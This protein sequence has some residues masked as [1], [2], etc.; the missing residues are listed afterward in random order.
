MAD[1]K[2]RIN[3]AWI[4]VPLLILM[5]GGWFIWQTFQ[6]KAVDTSEGLQILKG[7]S[8]QRVVVNEST[9]Q[10]NLTLNED[11]THESTGIGDRTA[12]LGK[13]VYFT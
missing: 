11:Y 8:L 1:K 3:W 4:L 13:S 9:Q 7:T 12:N 10:V 5:M 2:K 6:P